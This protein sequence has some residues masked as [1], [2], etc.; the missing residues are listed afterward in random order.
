MTE[1]AL[2]T[3]LAA[4]MLRPERANAI[5]LVH[6]LILYRS[7][8]PTCRIVTLLL[9]TE[10]EVLAQ[11]PAGNTTDVAALHLLE[12]RGYATEAVGR[13]DLLHLPGGIDV[14]LGGVDAGHWHVVGFLPSL[15]AAVVF[16][17]ERTL[18]DPVAGFV[19]FVTHVAVGRGGFLALYCEGCH[20]GA[21]C[22]IGKRRDGR[23]LASYVLVLVGIASSESR[24]GA[25]R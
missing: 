12:T 9:A 2:V 17:L 22:C 25:A 23:Y 11:R 18:L 7:G 10:E 3:L 4:A 13:G 21:D 8:K 19:A 15:V 6:Q 20:V 16:P 1:H 5:L 24:R 14:G